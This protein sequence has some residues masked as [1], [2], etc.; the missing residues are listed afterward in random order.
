MYIYIYMYQYTYI[1]IR[2][3]VFTY[4]VYMRERE[5]VPL[6]KLTTLKACE[7]I[8]L[9]ACATSENQARSWWNGRAI[10]P[11]WGF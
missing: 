6:P 4:I 3:C 2:V 10:P 5:R 7:A 8:G 9:K 11:I 1:Y